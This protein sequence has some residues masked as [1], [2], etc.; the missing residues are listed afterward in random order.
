MPSLSYE[1]YDFRV[2]FLKKIS[3]GSAV[4]SNPQRPERF[5]DIITISL[6]DHPPS[7]LVWRQEV[8]IEGRISLGDRL[9]FWLPQIHKIKK[10]N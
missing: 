1:L 7:S 4:G 5:V 6:V 3:P 2:K 10:N 8:G 9:N